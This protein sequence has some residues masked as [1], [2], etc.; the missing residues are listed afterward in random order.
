M[1]Q[2]VEKSLSLK[3]GYYNPLFSEMCLLVEY[4]KLCREPEQVLFDVYKLIGESYYLHDFANVENSHDEFDACCNAPDLHK[5]RKSVEWNEPKWFLPPDIS[6][7][8]SKHA[9]WL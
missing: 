3:E 8:Y 4:E 5:V 9:F 1:S 6:A 2:M 7:A